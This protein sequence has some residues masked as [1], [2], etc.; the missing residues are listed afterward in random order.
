MRPGGVARPPSTCEP[1]KNAFQDRLNT[2]G[3]PRTRSG[4]S[5]QGA[6][7]RSTQKRSAQRKKP[8]A[9]RAGI[10]NKKSGGE[11]FGSQTSCTLLQKPTRLLETKKNRP[12]KPFLSLG[13]GAQKPAHIRSKKSHQETSKTTS[14]YIKM[15]HPFAMFKA[16]SRC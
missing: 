12:P 13:Q 9:A 10:P 1:K 14:K 3:P 2:Y 15:L 8:V 4:V 5:P 7:Y 16:K 11:R 6:W